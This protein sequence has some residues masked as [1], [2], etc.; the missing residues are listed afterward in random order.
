MPEI[1]TKI[2]IVLGALGGWEAIK[3]GLEWFRNKKKNKIDVDTDNLSFYIEQIKF[4]E[5]RIT[6]LTN[7]VLQKD[8]IMEKMMIRVTDMEE[9]IKDLK[10]LEDIHIMNKCINYSCDKRK[11]N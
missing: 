9:K 5:E 11:R 8:S 3:Y 10:N 2:G 6:K 1:L 4:L 7:E